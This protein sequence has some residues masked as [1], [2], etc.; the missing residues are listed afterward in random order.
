M[1]C[2]CF[3]NVIHCIDWNSV[4]GYY[5]KSISSAC[6]R[7]TN[8]L[9]SYDG[10]HIKR[11]ERLFIVFV[12]LYRIHRHAYT[13]THARSYKQTWQNINIWFHCRPKNDCS[14]GRMHAFGAL[15]LHSRQLRKKYLCNSTERKKERQA[16]RQKSEQNELIKKEASEK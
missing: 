13:H 5:R 15:Q 8:W 7:C 1:W 2:V 10:A 12:E 11:F 6:T 3:I 14:H 4:V 16:G 9:V